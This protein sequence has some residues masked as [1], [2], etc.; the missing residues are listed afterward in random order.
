MLDTTRSRVDVET[1]IGVV[2]LIPILS[3]IF[4]QARSQILRFGRAK[5]IFR[6]AQILFLLYF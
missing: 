2:S 6:G 5:Y 3:Y 1:E 4:S